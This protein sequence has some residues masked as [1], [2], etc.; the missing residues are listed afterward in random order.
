MQT[1]KDALIRRQIQRREEQLV[2]KNERLIA[3]NEHQKEYRLYEEYTNQRR[4][5]NNLRRKNILQAHIEQKR[6]EAD[7]PSSHDYYFAAA[8]NRNRLKRKASMT[9]FVSFDDDISC[10]GSTFDLV[11][12]ASGKKSSKNIINCFIHFSYQNYF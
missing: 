5:Q 2:R 11:S 1:K 7:P 4:Q 12:I 3:A 8:R 6:L 10:C 9:S